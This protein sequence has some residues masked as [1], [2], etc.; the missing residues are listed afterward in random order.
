MQLRGA[1]G[2]VKIDGEDYTLGEQV[3]Y[4]DIWGQRQLPAVHVRAAADVA[5]LPMR[6]AQLLC[7]ATL[8]KGTQCL[9][10]D[11]VFG[12]KNFVNDITWYYETKP[13]FGF[14]ET[15]FT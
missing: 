13:Q 10:L 7:I 8:V 2:T 5:W 1:K 4:S 15:S 3:Q 11:E 9:I 6:T 14:A 12:E